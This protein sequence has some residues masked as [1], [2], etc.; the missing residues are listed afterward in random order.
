[1][2]PCAVGFDCCGDDD[3]C[4]ADNQCIV[5]EGDCDNNADCLGDLVCGADNCGI[6]NGGDRGGDYDGTDDCCEDPT[7]CPV[8]DPTE[9][10]QCA[11]ADLTCDSTEKDVCGN[12]LCQF[13]C[14]IIVNIVNMLIYVN[15]C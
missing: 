6:Y 4:T 8:M 7:V 13:T 3:C 15:I 1:M 5:G 2:N 12:P 10:E 9:G 14:N 11:M